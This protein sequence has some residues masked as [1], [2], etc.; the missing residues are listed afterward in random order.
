MADIVMSG[1]DEGY[2]RVSTIRSWILASTGVDFN[3]DFL[4]QMLFQ[5]ILVLQ[6]FFSLAQFLLCVS[7]LNLK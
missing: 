7:Q 2:G 5:E 1:W 3:L 4:E 6:H